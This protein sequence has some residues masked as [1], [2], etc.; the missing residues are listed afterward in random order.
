[1]S[2]QQLDTLTRQKKYAWAKYY[3]LQN[4]EHADNIRVYNRLTNL[5]PNTPQF[6]LDDIK[7][8]HL[9]LRKK[10]EC[11]ICLAVIEP[12]DMEITKCG[13]KYCKTCLDRLKQTP[14]KKCAL[15]RT[16]VAR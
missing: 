9:E 16:K 1:M 2:Q 15:C 6:V 4:R 13:H 5:P 11:P 7:S 8:L 12:E 10:I 3:A 14:Q